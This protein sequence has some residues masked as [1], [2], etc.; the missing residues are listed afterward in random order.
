MSPYQ[1]YR[2]AGL[3]VR[4]CKTRCS[5]YMCDA[6]RLAKADARKR[7]YRDRI[8]KGI[9]PRCLKKN[10]RKRTVCSGCAQ[11]EKE[12]AATKSERRPS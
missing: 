12:R 4:C 6:C 9:C 2:S 3:C 5:T 8:A 10:D 1:R 11:R 7:M